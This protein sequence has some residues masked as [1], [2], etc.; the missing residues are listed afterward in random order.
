MGGGEKTLVVLGSGL[1]HLTNLFDIISTQNFYEIPGLDLPTVEGHEGK[2]YFSD[3][4]IF[5]NGRSHYFEGYGLTS[6][7]MPL[8][9]VLNTYDINQVVLTSASGAL[10][11]RTE[12]GKVCNV[13]DFVCMPKVFNWPHYTDTIPLPKMEN[14]FCY[15]FHQ[16]PSLGTLTEYRFLAEIGAD[17]VGMSTYPE[18]V[19]L[20]QLGL[21]AKVL[22]VPVCQYHP[23]KDIVEPS[24][25]ELMEVAGKAVPKLYDI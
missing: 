7:V 13:C 21:T 15:A 4:F 9:F 24:H 3:D 14:G 23:F 1:Q 20:A 17:L 12:I 8:K 22:S 19:M 10:N 5:V 25:A 6:L 18:Y 2:F 11:P 16:G